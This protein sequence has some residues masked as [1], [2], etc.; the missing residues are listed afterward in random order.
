MQVCAQKERTDEIRLLWGIWKMVFYSDLDNTLIYS[1]KHDIGK[2]KRCVETYEGREISF[3]TEDSFRLL[4]E[5]NKK[6][7]FVPVTTRTVQQYQR[8]RLGIGV[9]EYAL[10]C[11]GGILLENG[12]RDPGWHEA[13]RALV[14]D[15]QQELHRAEKKLEGDVDVNF[16]VRN[17]EDLFLFTKSAHPERTV[18]NLQNTLDHWLVDVFSNGVKIYVLPKKLTKGAAVRRFQEKLQ[19]GTGSAIGSIAAG[20][21]AFD[22]PMLL[23]ADVALMPKEMQARGICKEAILYSD[24]KRI[25]S[26]FLLEYVSQAAGERGVQSYYSW[27]SRP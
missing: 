16:E 22:I 11:N 18:R 15:C 6:V 12:E 10:V 25:F 3:M 24:G 23:E 2:E 26:D 27:P 1:Y 9:P 20:D 17:I 5:V 4:Q 19:Q 8:I 14:A 7:L 21:S 13:S